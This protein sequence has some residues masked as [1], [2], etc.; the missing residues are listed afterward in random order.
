MQLS[1]PFLAISLTAALCACTVAPRQGSGPKPV[2]EPVSA[3]V[4]KPMA[5]FARMVGGEWSGLSALQAWHWGP[6]RHSMR[7]GELEV[8]YWHPGRRQVRLLS[9]HADIPAVGRGSGEGTI[10]FEGE[11]ANGVLDLYQPRGLRKLAMRWVFEGPDKYRDTLLEDSGTGFKPLAEW[12]RIRVPKQ[13]DSPPRAAEKTLNS[14]EHLKAFE[15]LLGRTWEAQASAGDSVTGKAVHIQS[16]FEFVPDYVYWRVLAP[17]KDGEPAH[18]LDAYFYQDVR[19]GTLR[20]LALS[21]S[22]GVYEGTLKVLGRGLD[23]GIAGAA[24]QLD[25]TGYEGDRVVPLIARFDFQ[26]DETFRQRVWSLEGAERTL[27]V[28]VQ[29]KQ[30]APK[31][32]HP[33]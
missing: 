6:G 17:S 12:E 13:S 25:L 33:R 2:Q 22:G 14:P 1:R 15:P 21:N 24:L 26:K 23:D 27:I 28:D 20:C 32:D 18:L 3:E 11:T 10:E 29:H 30:L 19:T 8:I 4:A 16:T 5:S 7:G 9:M 31:S